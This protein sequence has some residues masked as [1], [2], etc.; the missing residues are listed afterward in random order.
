MR[1]LTQN[2][3][4]KRFSCAFGV[5]SH[6]AG[7]RRFGRYFYAI[8][9]IRHTS[10]KKMLLGVW[11]KP[12]RPSYT[13][14]WSRP[15]PPQANQKNRRSGLLTG[16]CQR[17]SVGGFIVKFPVG[18]PPRAPK[19]GRPGFP[20]GFLKKKNYSIKKQGA[21]H[22]FFTSKVRLVNGVTRRH[23]KRIIYQKTQAQRAL[24]E[25]AA[26]PVMV[27]CRPA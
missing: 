1:S 11:L 10:R 17:H 8:S 13:R 20:F 14:V 15:S 12:T 5:K 24:P 7:K 4:R 6:A 21:H 19:N 27:Y 3:R 26:K 23:T 22:H 18:P 16:A 9:E 25:A 2:F